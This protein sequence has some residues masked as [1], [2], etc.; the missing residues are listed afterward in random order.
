MLRNLNRFDEALSS[1]ETAIELKPDYPAA[2]YNRANVLLLDV[3]RPEEALQAYERAL[4]LQPEFVEAWNNRGNALVR[5]GRLEEALGS[6]DRALAMKPGFVGA[7][8]SRAQALLELGRTDE[9]IASFMGSARLAYGSMQNLPTPESPSSA[10]K[11]RHDH[12][13]REYL[14][15]RK[16]E[17][18]NLAHGPAGARLPGAAVSS[19][20]PDVMGQW[21]QREIAVIDGFLAP[22]ALKS[23]RRFLPGRTYLAGHK[24]CQRL[25]RRLSRNRLRLSAAGPDRGGIARPIRGYFGTRPLLYMWAFKYDSALPGTPIHADEAAVNVNFWLTPDSANLD[26]ESGGLILWDTAAPLDWHFAKFNSDTPAIR[27]FLSS[28]GAQ[29]VTVPYRTNRAVVFDSD[30]FHETGALH[31]KDGYLNRR[32]NVTM[33]FGRR[34]KG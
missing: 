3:N 6:Y 24:K 27:D 17:T 29:A 16:D 31:F 12:E 13:Q 14:A 21:R 20:R 22:E 1:F 26:P 28:A 7:I 11:I 34:Q 30:L 4:A 8:N 2:L 23:L 5:L 10:L 18:G 15:I 33:L 32:I 19:A 25:S 9:A